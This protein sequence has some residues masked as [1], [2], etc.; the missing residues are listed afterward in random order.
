[1]YHVYLLMENEEHTKYVFDG[2]L[3]NYKENICPANG[4]IKYENGKVRC[5]LHSEDE[6]DG[7]EGD[8]DDGSVPYL[9]K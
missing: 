8:E 4:D 3:Q 6:V 7:N 9:W 5:V 2:F 1:M